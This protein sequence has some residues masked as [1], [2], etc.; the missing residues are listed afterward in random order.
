MNAPVSSHVPWLQLSN[1][2]LIQWKIWWISAMDVINR[3]E[4]SKID[5]V[6]LLLRKM[7]E[8]DVARGNRKTTIWRVSA[9][10]QGN[11]TS[12]H[13][14]LTLP[15]WA[16]TSA[17]AAVKR[18]AVSLLACSKTIGSSRRRLIITT[19]MEMAA[20]AAFNSG[21]E[22]LWAN[23]VPKSS[24][25]SSWRSKRLRSNYGRIMGPRRVCPSF[26]AVK[27]TSRF[28]IQW[29]MMIFNLKMK[30]TRN[31]QIRCCRRMR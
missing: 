7:V 18:T 16:Q 2:R 22:L 29:R 10:T 6:D 30:M 20:S 14:P 23:P 26:L 1:W 5:V 17:V 25:D 13:P 21:T 4:L 9:T 24:E 12:A 31:L 27:R 15:A 3:F 8:S 11:N 28:K 19:T